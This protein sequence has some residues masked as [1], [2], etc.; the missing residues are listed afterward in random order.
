M[1]CVRGI[2]RCTERKGCR[3]L[4]PVG[5][6][7]G[8]DGWPARPATTVEAALCRLFTGRVAHEALRS[9]FKV[10][11]A[12]AAGASSGMANT[13]LTLISHRT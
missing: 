3:A 6:V 2:S 13:E 8:R 5:H 9:L 7:R 10:S 4:V 1:N 11:C 12:M